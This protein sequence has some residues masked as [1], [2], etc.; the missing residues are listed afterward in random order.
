MILLVFFSFIAGFVTILSP[1][2][3]PILP[4]VLSGSINGG[5]KRPIGIV[6]G[7]VL[8]FTLFT[9]FLSAIVRATGISA[10]ILRNISVVIILLFGATL[11]LP[12]FQVLME[13]LFTR[14]ASS[15]SGRTP[16]GNGFWSGLLL[17]VSLGLIWTPCV[18]PII[19]SVITLAATSSVNGS[20]IIITFAYSLGTAI[21]MFAIT[22]GG[23]TLLA[24]VPWLLKNTGNI[25]KVFGILM[26]L[27]A[28]G[29]F[30]NLDRKFQNE[31]LDRFP[32][33]GAG[34]TKLEDN[35]AVK[36]ELE[37]VKEQKDFIQSN[38]N[39]ETAPALI[40]GGEWFNSEPLTMKDLRGKVVLV[41]FW[42]YTC[43]NC[44]RT[45]PYLKSWY[46]KYEKSGLVVLG[47][48][49][50]EFAFER[51]AENVKQAIADFELKYPVMQDN[52]Y[53]TWTAFNNRYW[54]AHYLIDKNG[55]IRYTH[56]GE[57]E[58]DKT[59]E[60]IQKL[61]EEKGAKVSETIK[62]EEYSIDSKTP[63]TYL[64]YARMEGFSS[65]ESPKRNSKQ[66]YSI[67]ENLPLNSF[68]FEGEWNI[69]EENAKPSKGAA[70]E[71]KFNAKN[72]YLVLNAL[73]GSSNVKIILDGEVVDAKRQGIDV[74][75]G[76]VE[77][78]K[79]KLYHLI[80]LSTSEIH[81]MRIE[82]LD[83]NAAAFAFTFG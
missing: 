42:T 39:Y 19:A 70:L 47:V 34:L 64:G 8:S 67:P 79:N 46:Q 21:P 77:V 59:E 25:Q 82:F 80:K 63:E 7:F 72:V 20:A 13:K 83:G 18:G 14:L 40:P 28:I 32:Q 30:F 53:A 78:T 3:L 9:L 81:I 16:K 12:N 33:Y 68:A 26:I 23:R 57:G 6:T 1:C 66:T 37:K 15:V 38:S 27:V 17:G 74:A 61:L 55:L 76:T 71:Y 10:D 5:H 29:M 52:D 35:Q 43:I 45:F 65:P 50:P 24:K 54:P 49:T 44:I 58:Y 11:L 2:I 48:H 4:V 36:N 69:E 62:N 31:V 73:S 75:Q 22:Y 56:F 60:M 41:D 51:D